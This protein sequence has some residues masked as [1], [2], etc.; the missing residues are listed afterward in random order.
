MKQLW[1]AAALAVLVS[2]CTALAADAVV[3]SL[4]KWTLPADTTQVAGEVAV[5]GSHDATKISAFYKDKGF[6]NGD[7]YLLVRQNRVAFA[8]AS[9]AVIPQERALTPRYDRPR[10]AY[11][12]VQKEQ[13][14]H[15]RVPEQKDRLADRRNLVVY[16]RDAEPSLKPSDR[17]AF[18]AQRDR[19]QRNSMTQQMTLDE[20]AEYWNNE[21]IPAIPDRAETVE[22]MPTKGNRVYTA[23]WTTS[24]MEKGILYREITHAELFKKNGQVYAVL[25]SADD[26]QREWLSRL[27]QALTAWH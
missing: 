16:R 24:R 25:I 26:R 27:T 19:L 4:G 14:A 8:Y 12:S 2:G 20:A 21:V 13:S 5:R 1:I 6:K 9:L 22:F 7:Y 11:R 17:K 3:P 18:A 10:P 15:Y 23:T